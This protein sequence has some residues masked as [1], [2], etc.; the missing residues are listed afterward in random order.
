MDG[1]FYLIAIFNRHVGSTFTFLLVL[2]VLRFALTSVVAVIINYS[3]LFN[4]Q[5]GEVLLLALLKNK[6]LR[7]VLED[8]LT[9]FS[10]FSALSYRKRL[11]NSFASTY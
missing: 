1:Q 3:R 8:G 7:Y 11:F 10:A 5:E 4:N 6:S 9:A 2:K